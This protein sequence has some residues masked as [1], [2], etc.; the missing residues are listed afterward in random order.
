M[1]WIEVASGCEMPDKGERVLRT[2]HGWEEVAW[3][4]GYFSVPGGG[5]KIGDITHWMR[6]TPPD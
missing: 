3:E 6:V 4:D 2:S 5:E 1:S